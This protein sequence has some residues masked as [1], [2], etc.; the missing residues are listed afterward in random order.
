MGMSVVMNIEYVYILQQENLFVY[1]VNSDLFRK[2]D[3]VT[4]FLHNISREILA[5]NDRASSQRFR[6]LQHSAAILR[7][8]RLFMSNSSLNLTVSF[9]NVT[10]IGFTP[11]ASSS[12]DLA[13]YRIH[14]IILQPAEYIFREMREYFCHTLTKGMSLDI[15]S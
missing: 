11:F 8:S 3:Q 2:L 14:N 12:F 9:S 7:C 5:D 6:L 4:S 15:A 13:T 1:F 10:T